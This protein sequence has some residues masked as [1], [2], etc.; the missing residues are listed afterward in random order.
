MPGLTDL[1]LALLHAIAS[2]RNCR[3]GRHGGRRHHR[4]IL[5]PAPPLPPLVVPHHRVLEW[6]PSPSPDRQVF[7]PMEPSDPDTYPWGR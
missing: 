2:P 5:A 4:P 1:V 7:R 3:R 6:P